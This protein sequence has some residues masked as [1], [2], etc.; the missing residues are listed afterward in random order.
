M[1]ELTMAGE[2]MAWG[3][4]L[5]VFAEQEEGEETLEIVTSSNNED[6]FPGGPIHQIKKDELC[7]QTRLH[8]ASHKGRM[9]W[10]SSTELTLLTCYSSFNPNPVV[11]LAAFLCIEVKDIKRRIKYLNRGLLLARTDFQAIKAAL[12]EEFANAD[13]RGRT[14]ETNRS[15]SLYYCSSKTQQIVLHPPRRNEMV[16]KKR[17]R[18]SLCIIESSLPSSHGADVRCIDQFTILTLADV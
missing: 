9:K 11:S 2:S 12:K 14:K 8:K 18:R 7:P 10:R 1:P 6:D 5:L 17:H 3:I 13:A 15:S 4:V 16:R